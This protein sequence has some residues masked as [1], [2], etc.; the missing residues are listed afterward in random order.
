MPVNRTPCTE[1]CC[2]GVGLSARPADACR[3]W[4]FGVLILVGSTQ[5]VAADQMPVT[6]EGGVLPTNTQFYGWT[7]TNHHTS[8]I[9]YIEFPHYHGDTFNAPPGWSSEWK[10]QRRVGGGKDAPGWVRTSVADPVDGILPGRSAAF[11][12]RVSREGA[13]T[14]SGRVTVRFADGTETIVADVELPC[15]PGF[16]EQNIM[17]FTLAGIFVIALA[18]HLRRRR[19]APRS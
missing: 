11:E 16:T 17:L 2:A 4:W 3:A 12:M 13:L 1:P 18:I 7:V 5:A 19:K 14:R 8:P 9:V 15:A 6:I 10:N